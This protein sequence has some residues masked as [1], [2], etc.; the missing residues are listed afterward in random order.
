MAIPKITTFLMFNGQAEK[1]QL[2]YMLICLKM[3]KFLSLVKYTESDN[4]PTGKVQHAIFR[5]KDQIFYG[6][7]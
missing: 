4:A 7:R 1:K 3:L 2:I 5:L 6:Y